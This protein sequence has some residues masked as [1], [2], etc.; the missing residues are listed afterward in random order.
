[1]KQE[2]IFEKLFSF[3][4]KSKYSKENQIT[5]EESMT[6][7]R[8]RMEVLNQKALNLKDNYPDQRA[9]IQNCL[10]LINSIEPS[11]SVRAGKFE[12]QISVAIT[13]VSTACDKIFT[14]KDVSKLDSLINALLR[15]IRER[16]NADIVQE[17]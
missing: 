2:N 6:T 5:A 16:Q 1:M 3:F 12:Q 15:S 4:N 17:E 11:A 14:N 8:S 7:L 10:D 9:Q 13:Q